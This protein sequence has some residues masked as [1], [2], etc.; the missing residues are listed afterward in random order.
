MT[1]IKEHEISDKALRE[2]AEKMMIAART[3]P[4]GRGQNT[5]TLAL[6]E[7]DDIEKIAKRMK[8]IDKQ[9]DFSAFTRD[10]NNILN[11]S[12]MLLMGT[13]IKPLGLKKCGMCGYA[14]CAEKEEHPDI[15]CVLNVT[16]LGIA[17]GSAASVAMDNRVDNRIL[18]TAGQAVL[19]LHLLGDDVKVAYCI[20]ISSSSKNIFFDR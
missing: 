18:Y 8:E 17:V 7:K 9:M 5:I 6:A 16:D 4:K 19:D 15:P 2:I 1:L 12:V 14:N 11:C 20:P 3:A 13:S 10:A